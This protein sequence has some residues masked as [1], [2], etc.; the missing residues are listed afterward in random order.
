M[1]TQPFCMNDE[2]ALT[3]FAADHRCMRC[4]ARE[5]EPRC[6]FK[7]LPRAVAHISF[8]CWGKSTVRS[9]SE[10]CSTQ[11]DPL[12]ERLLIGNPNGKPR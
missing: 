9:L 4:M 8:A 2:R 3:K 1:N 10:S 12:A 11:P 6:C 7:W 5:E